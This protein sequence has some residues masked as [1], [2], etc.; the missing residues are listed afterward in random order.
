MP[1]QTPNLDDSCKPRLVSF[2][3]IQKDRITGN[4]LL[5]YPEGAMELAD[6]AAEILRFCDGKHSFSQIVVSLH[7]D[8]NAD[9]SA[10]TND[11]RE[12]LIRLHERG[13]LV[14]GANE[15]TQK[16]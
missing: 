4:Q 3:R 7:A 11:V 1:H 12:F 15:E 16:P 5:L 13:L 8:F 9:P 14:I 10:I 6:S 2:A